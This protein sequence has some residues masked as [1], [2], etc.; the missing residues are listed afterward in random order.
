MRDI[1]QW[2]SQYHQCPVILG[3]ATP[4]LESYARAEKNVYEFII[5]T[6]SGE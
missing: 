2:R 6:K 3:S 1:A 5:F 4:S